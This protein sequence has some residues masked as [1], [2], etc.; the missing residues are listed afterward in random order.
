MLKAR[1]FIGLLVSVASIC[2]AQRVEVTVPLAK[3]LNGHLVLVIA[4]NEK[5]EPRMQLS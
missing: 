3:P 5:P 1:F 4:K 2:H